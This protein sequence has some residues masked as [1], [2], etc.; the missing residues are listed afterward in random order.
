M[1][2]EQPRREAA[3]PYGEWADSDLMVYRYLASAPHA[4]DRDHAENVL[5]LRRDLRTGGGVL[6][7][8]LSIA[9]LDAAGVNVDPVNVLALTHIDVDVLDGGDDVT[10]VHFRSQVTREARTMVFTEAVMTDATDRSRLIGFGSANWSVVTP[11]VGDFVY[12]EPG[13]GIPD[14][15]DAPALWEAYTGRR[16]DDGRLEIPGLSPEVGTLRLHHG[17]MSVVTEAAAL[18]AT[19]PLF[20]DGALRVEHFAMTLLSPARMGPFVATP[21][22]EGTGATIGVRVELRDEG[23]GDRLVARTWV[24]LRRTGKPPAPLDAARKEC[25]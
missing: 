10:E 21:V 18:D 3:S 1:S 7:A 12:P 6:A 23:C 15:P 13:E 24:R 20:A 4:L 14:S 16:R 8:P 2:I 19:R 25:L 11:T 9:M 5:P 22:V 17:P